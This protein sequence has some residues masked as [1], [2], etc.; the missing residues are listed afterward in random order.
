MND[1]DRDNRIENLEWLVGGLTVSLINIVNTILQ[2]EEI[3]GNTKEKLIHALTVLQVSYFQPWNAI[4][5]PDEPI[6]VSAD[7]TQ[8]AYHKIP[9]PETNKEAQ[10]DEK[11]VH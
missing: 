6:P 11:L 4:T 2:D 8:V 5:K 3:S 9:F 7:G 1:Q 10:I